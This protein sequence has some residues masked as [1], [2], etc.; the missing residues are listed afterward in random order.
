M[1]NTPNKPDPSTGTQGIPP[2]SHAP[3][4][5]DNGNR[6]YE[7]VQRGQLHTLSY[8]CYFLDTQTKKIVSP[9]HDIPLVNAEHSTPTGDLV[10]NMVVEIPRWTNAKME[11]NKQLKLNPIVQDEK[12][13]ECGRRRTQARA[14]L[15]QV[16]RVSCTTSFRITAICG[17]TGRCR[18][19]GKIPI[20][21]TR[22][23]RPSGTTI[24]WTSARS[25]RHFMPLVRSSR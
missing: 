4:S 18:K 5:A 25:A 1:S 16:N 14:S 15:L 20:T 17:T 9:F 13:G 6:R 10:Y 19:P 7:I 23:R 8:R 2:A 22:T 11:I 12:N 24:R 3:Q 21:S